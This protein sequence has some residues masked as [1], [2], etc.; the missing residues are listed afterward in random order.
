MNNLSLLIYLADVVSSLDAAFEFL[1]SISG[2][3][4]LFS[5]FSIVYFH[6]DDFEAEAK[7]FSLKMLRLS[8]ISFFVCLFVVAL[9]P[10]KDT[11]YLI[12]ASEAGEKIITN[13]EVIETVEIVKDYLLKQIKP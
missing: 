1:T 13:P 12:A 11:L 5:L 10:E 4:W 7:R 6:V 3:C 9:T 2:I 8:S